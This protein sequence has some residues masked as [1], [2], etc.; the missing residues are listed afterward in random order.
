MRFPASL[1]ACLVAL[2]LATDC[3]LVSAAEPLRFDRDIR[4]ILSDKCFFCHGPDEAHREAGLRLD[5]EGEARGVIDASDGQSSEL[6]RRVVSDDPNEIMPPPDAH[7]ELSADERERLQRWLKEGAPWTEHWSFTA[8]TR[9]QVPLA[10]TPFNNPIDGFIEKRLGEQGLLFSPP[11]EREKLIRRVT[12]D[13][14]GLPPTVEEVDAFLVDDSANAF[15]R[16]VDRLLDSPHYGQRMAVMWMDAARYGDTSVYHADGPR[17]M[18]A[19]RD[20]IVDAYNQNMPFDQFS[21]NQLAGDLIPD[22]TLQQQILAG[23]NRNNGTTDEGGAIAEEYRVEYAV[24][25]VKTTSTVWLGLTME[26]AQCHDHKYDPISQEEYYQFYA[27]FNVSSDGGMQTRKGNADPK[28]E[29]PDPEKTRQLPSVEQAQQE[30]SERLATIE[31]NC[32]EDFAAWLEAQQAKAGEQPSLPPDC[33]LNFAITTGEGKTITNSVDPEHNGE[34]QGEVKWSQSRE[35]WALDFNGKN[36]VDL[37]DVANFE[38]S[39][40][41]SYG[42]WVKPQKGATGALLARMDSPN[43]YRG[44]DML[45][46]DDVIS[47]HLIHNWPGNAIKVKTKKR[48]TPDKWQHVF[49]TY[50]GSSKASGIKIYVDG[51]PWEWTIEQDGL[52]ETIQTPKSLLI[53]SRHGGSPLRGSVDEVQVFQRELSANEI[54]M[55]V[56]SSHLQTMLAMAPGERTEPQR[57]ALRQYYLATE[58]AEYQE[59]QKQITSLAAKIETLKK[60][61]TTV[62]VMG[63]MGKPRETFVLSRGAYDSPTDQKVI[64]GTPA[65]LPPMLA[66]APSSGLGPNRL[67]LAQWLFRDDHPLTARV[68]VNRYWQM[69]FGNG[70]V[71]TPE[72][73]GAQG[74]FPSHPELLDWLA[75]DFREHGWDIKRTL[76]QI[77]MS[78]TYQQS[79][80]VG[81]AAYLA[82]PPNRWL[83]RGSRYRLQGEFLRDSALAISGLLVDDFGGPGVKPYQPG[84][85]WAEVGL[86]GNPKFKQDQGEDLYRRSLYTYWKRSAPPPAMQIFDAPTREKCIIRRARTNTPLQSLVTLNDTQFVETARHFA[87][88]LLQLEDLGDDQ[89]IE[90]GFRLATARRPK[91]SEREVLRQMLASARQRYQADP[92]SAS[93]LLKIGEAVRD[94]SL[95]PATH[96]AWTIVA[97]AILNLDET[98]TRE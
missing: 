77:V 33:L 30:S 41:F 57:Q 69:L 84:G 28:L 37:G 2:L 55:L 65:V 88:R 76:K 46:G 78:Q 60:P 48:L 7:K 83:A 53:G 39:E 90:A 64:A 16:V 25:R 73:F 50:D 4:P 86:G 51:E 94:D 95:A 58:N 36:Y 11:A 82:D 6:M 59:L 49:A 23:F 71:A 43:A 13:L 38:R 91:A 63:D 5:L 67:G 24:D 17:D 40:S 47:V 22:A 62:M 44:F 79:S 81:P 29:I 15:E 68:T 92:V 45:V 27:F 93:E 31:A 10:E 80:R 87:Q 75:V 8:P 1:A 54:K 19:W 72:D 98:L 89:R 35:D 34:I 74:E 26:C 61:L 21:I 20:V 96:A 18:W 66:D 14:T 70:L 9:S 52:T 32:E 12:L 42:G 3:G 97:S 85:L 56:D